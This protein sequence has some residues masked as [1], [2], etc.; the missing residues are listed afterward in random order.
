MSC[1]R[2]NK[3]T[4]PPQRALVQTVWR[5]TLHENSHAN[6]STRSQSSIKSIS[7]L[8]QYWVVSRV[9]SYIYATLI[10]KWC[11]EWSD[12]GAVGGLGVCA[13]ERRTIWHLHCSFTLA[14]ALQGGRLAEEKRTGILSRCIFTDPLWLSDLINTLSATAHELLNMK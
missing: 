13:E 12:A 3:N 8:F 14:V 1:L 4:P 11:Q 7:S 2:T 6:E 10:C 9:H 5:L